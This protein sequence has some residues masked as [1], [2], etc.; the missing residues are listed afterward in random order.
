MSQEEYVLLF[1]DNQTKT[2]WVRTQIYA[3]A[4]KEAKLA[5][6]AFENLQKEFAMNGNYSGFR[7]FEI[8][9]NNLEQEQPF[10]FV[11]VQIPNS[12]RNSYNNPDNIIPNKIGGR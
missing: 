7:M 8:R 12:I 2:V 10:S 4:S 1:V 3:A 6:A 9:K 11:E 5:H